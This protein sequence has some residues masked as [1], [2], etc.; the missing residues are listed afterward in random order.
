[1]S[2]TARATIDL[3]ALRHNLSV[4]HRHA[5]DSHIM[6]CIKADAYGHGLVRVAAALDGEVDAF[7]V[8][9]VAEAAELRAAGIASAIVLLEGVFD[10]DEQALAGELGLTLVLHGPEQLMLLD[11]HEGPPFTVWLKLDSGMG[12]LG[13]QLPDAKALHERLTGSPAVVGAPGLMTHLSSADVVDADTTRWQLDRFRD[14]TRGLEG[15]RSIANS[16][17][18][19]CWPDA[20]LD[21]VRPGLMLYGASPLDGRS[22][23]ELDLRPVMRLESS[24]ISVKQLSA[25]GRVG[26]GATWTAPEDMKLGLAGIGYGD[27]YPWRAAPQAAVVIA[28]QRIPIVGRISMDM[29]A[30]DIR[31]LEQA[32]V[33]DEVVLWGPELPVETVAGWAGTIPYELLCGVTRRVEM[34]SVE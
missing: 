8:A 16:A 15:P 2:L 30:L 23:A 1:L 4:V 9:R 14:A 17:G 25:G 22:A 10:S 20:Q 24:L 13:F 5:P 6:A 28:G 18:L 21:W 27:G 31:S 3:A 33:G 19:M 32:A 34:R 11:Q 7:A 12:R 29:L 26:Y